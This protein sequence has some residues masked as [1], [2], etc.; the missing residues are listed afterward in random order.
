M[1][2]DVPTAL[3]SDGA[4]APFGH[5]RFAARSLF[6]VHRRGPS[7]PA[8]RAHE[9]PDG[10]NPSGRRISRAHAIA[11]TLVAIPITQARVL[12]ATRQ[13]W[14]ARAR[15]SVATR[16]RARNGEGSKRRGPTRPVAKSGESIDLRKPVGHRVEEVCP[17][18]APLLETIRTSGSSFWSPDL[19]ERRASHAP[20]PQPAPETSAQAGARRHPRDRHI[21]CAQPVSL[22]H[23]LVRDP[24]LVARTLKGRRSSSKSC[25]ATRKASETGPFRRAVDRRV[26]RPS[27]AA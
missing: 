2:T 10:R 16:A 13:S 21:V 11:T 20:G 8:P 19:E 4:S 17:Y 22:Y 27:A 14:I 9:R 24:R 1:L 26:C 18:P 6:V 3:P 12:S 15:F 7:P 25:I 5:R 23:V